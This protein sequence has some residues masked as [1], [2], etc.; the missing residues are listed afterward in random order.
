M[1]PKNTGVLVVASVLFVTGWTLATA[2][3]EAFSRERSTASPVRGVRF[4]WLVLAAQ[5]PG[6]AD[7]LA[8]RSVYAFFLLLPDI[9]VRCGTPQQCRVALLCRAFGST[10][11]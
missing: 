11:S 7:A 5:S 3:L 9:M 1:R 10:T 2:L 6:A 4:H 8:P